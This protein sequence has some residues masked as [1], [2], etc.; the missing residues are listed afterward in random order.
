[1]PANFL[2]YKFIQLALPKAK[3]VHTFR[4][5]WDNAI[6]LFKANFQD[7]IIYAS[8]FF[9][10]ANEYSNYSALMRFWKRNSTNPPFLDV[11][12]EKMVMIQ[13][14]EISF[15]MICHF[16]YLIYF[17][18]SKSTFLKTQEP[19]QYCFM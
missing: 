15:S 8:S 11:D 2:Y 7:T 10:I 16:L 18:R 5:S 4:N 12:Y 6:S 13:I 3:F 9:G 17:C 19:Y 1:M 14:I